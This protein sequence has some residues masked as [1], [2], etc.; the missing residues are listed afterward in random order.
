MD[1]ITI[2][3]SSCLLGEAVRHDGRDKRN[4]LIIEELGQLFAFRSCCPEVAIGLGVP[5]PPIQLV[6][7]G[8]GSGARARGV[9]DPSLD[10]TEALVA[11][12]GQF[13]RS[14]AISGFVFKRGSPSCGVESVPRV[15]GQGVQLADG[16]GVFAAALIA[17]LPD[18]PVAEESRLEDPPWRLNF[19]ECVRVYHRWQRLL[20]LGLDHAALMGF[21]ARHKLSLLARDE[22]AYR[23]LGPLVARAGGSDLARVA[24]DYFSALMAAM[25]RLPTP[26]AEVNVMQHVLGFFRDDMTAGQRA[27][28]LEAIEDCRRERSGPEQALALIRRQLARHPHDWLLQQYYLYPG[29][30][31]GA[32]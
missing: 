3:V 16:R 27:E 18:L 25:R 28:L 13:V 2:G 17:R 8:P 5:R 32:Q 26:G 31:D 4:G 7:T 11:Q 24:D 30:G 23:R 6:A 12:A 20:A 10:V 9:A 14:G 15:S 29:N 22:A 1:R 19:I 21:H